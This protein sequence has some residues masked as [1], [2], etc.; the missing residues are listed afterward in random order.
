[1]FTLIDPQGAQSCD[2][3][4]DRGA[5]ELS[6]NKWAATPRLNSEV[7]GKRD[8]GLPSDQEQRDAIG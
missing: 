5:T 2:V 1:M 7:H 8:G 6:T 4:A 3:V